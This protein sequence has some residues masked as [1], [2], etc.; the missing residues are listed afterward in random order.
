LPPAPADLPALV[1]SAQVLADV[2]RGDGTRC[3]NTA[4][5]SIFEL[6]SQPADLSR[7][8]FCGRNFDG[9]TADDGIRRLMHALRPIVERCS[10]VDRH[11]AARDDSAV[12][13]EHELT[14]AVLDAVANMSREAVSLYLKRLQD[15][16]E[17]A[18]RHNL[19]PVAHSVASH[20]GS[21]V[22]DYTENVPRRE[23]ALLSAA[24]DAFE[25]GDDTPV[26]DILLFRERN[27]ALLGRFRASMVDLSAEL[28]QDAAPLTLLASARDIYR[29][30]VQP[31]LGDLEAA[32][33]E[34]RIRFLIRSLVGASA[35]TLAP[36]EPVHA[37]EVG[38][39]LL[40]STVNYRFSRDKLLREHPFGLLHQITAEFSVNPASRRTEL[41]LAIQD[42]EQFLR[43]ILGHPRLYRQLL[44]EFWTP[45][46]DVA[47]SFG[48][49]LDD[50][51]VGAD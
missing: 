42:P 5:R 48:R 26:E 39:S 2:V 7:L 30:R 28:Q 50:L 6:P 44:G 22:G 8:I 16:F 18:R 36:V 23:A 17:L 4:L 51:P 3:M 40:G 47:R 35:I 20:V 13:C 32:M 19:A 15:A 25:V 43:S 45:R 34:S 41:E 49:I 37:V 38:A 10:A 27:R 31:A 33:S 21:L 11:E 9:A 1:V 14:P 29:N 12:T 24:V 46:V